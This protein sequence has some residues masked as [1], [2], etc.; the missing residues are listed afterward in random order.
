MIT[1]NEQRALRE[2]HSNPNISLRVL[3]EKLALGGVASA[4]HIINSLEEKGYLIKVG[5][6][7]SKKYHLTAK[8][9]ALENILNMKPEDL[10]PRELPTVTNNSGIY[11]IGA[12]ST[13]ATSEEVE[14]FEQFTPK[15]FPNSTGDTV[16]SPKEMLSASFTKIINSP[17]GLQKYGDIIVLGIILTAMVL[18]ASYLLLKDKWIDAFVPIA[19]ILLAVLILNKK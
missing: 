14:K 17:E 6:A 3:V 9:L 13:T 11:V 2:I 19:L 10:T 15:N 4:S 16:K 8:A 1:I 18:P 7:T 5:V 12:Q